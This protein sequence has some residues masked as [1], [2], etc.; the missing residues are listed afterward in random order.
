M[1]QARA[2]T[3]EIKKREERVEILL[4]SNEVRNA[5]NK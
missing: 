3:M 2:L 1:R 5:P 4:I